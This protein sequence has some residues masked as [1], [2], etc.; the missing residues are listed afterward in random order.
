[1]QQNCILQMLC[2]VQIFM[3]NKNCMATFLIWK[4]YRLKFF[5]LVS[6]SHPA[7]L[8]VVYTKHKNI[9]QAF[10]FMYIV[11]VLSKSRAGEILL[12][13]EVKS[14]ST[15]QTFVSRFFSLLKCVFYI[16]KIFFLSF[17]TCRIFCSKWHFYELF[18]NAW[19]ILADPPHGFSESPSLGYSCISPK[20]H[21]GWILSCCRKTELTEIASSP[22]RYDKPD[23]SHGILRFGESI[24]ERILE[25]HFTYS[26]SL[27]C[28]I[29]IVF[30]Y[31]YHWNT[32]QN[33]LLSVL[34]M[35]CACLALIPPN[36]VQLFLVPAVLYLFSE[37]THLKE[38]RIDA[39]LQHRL[40]F[41][42]YR[43]HLALGSCRLQ[44]TEFFCNGLNSKMK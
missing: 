10:H 4:C 3:F 40:S 30:Q 38:R 33:S 36:S 19:G 26:S 28:V 32:F 22:H 14:Y 24:F 9:W 18:M 6:G 21:A 16:V 42:L 1:M 39:W 13:N 43:W 12:W 2:A 44:K 20:E 37:H 34:L 15:T 27:Q 7:L 23:A 17:D 41:I 35:H 29:F 8:A 31:L 5:L 25:V 11:C